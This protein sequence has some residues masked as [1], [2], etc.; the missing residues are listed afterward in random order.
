[1]PRQPSVR[2]VR[3]SSLAALALIAVCATAACQSN[4]TGPAKL[5]ELGFSCL[6]DLDDRIEGVE[7]PV[8]TDFGTTFRVTAPNKLVTVS[9]RGTFAEGRRIWRWD[10]DD[11]DDELVTSKARPTQGFWFH[12]TFP[13]AQFSLPLDRTGDMLGLYRKDDEA[14]W[15]LGFASK[16][17][18]PVAKR[19]LARYSHPIAVVRF[20]LYAGRSWTS[21]AKLSGAV[22]LGLPYAGEHRYH[23]DVESAG[24]L[25]LPEVS[26]GPALRVQ[27]LVENQPLVGKPLV[28][29]QSS[30]VFECFG[31]VAR[32]V[33]AQKEAT[34]GTSTGELW[35]YHP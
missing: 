9:T 6:P 13:D 2:A 19:S 30:I 34:D 32:L 18:E 25:R 11:K 27:T 29:H 8:R 12:K 15:L 3:P 33:S 16:T 7:M 21:S 17:E 22:V 24:T 10:D 26:F 5:P 23:V 35:R 14:L 28:Q 1:M 20:P 31:E 4:G